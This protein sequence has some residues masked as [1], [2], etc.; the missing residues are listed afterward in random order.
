MILPQ[1]QHPLISEAVVSL[2]GINEVVEDGQIQEIAGFLELLGELNIGGAGAAV[3]AGVV[4]DL[5]QRLFAALHFDY[6]HSVKIRGRAALASGK[7]LGLCVR[8][9]P[10]YFGPRKQRLEPRLAARICLSVCGCQSA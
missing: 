4:V 5:I 10:E 6:G 9:V 7:W 8:Q 2:V 3:A 1:L